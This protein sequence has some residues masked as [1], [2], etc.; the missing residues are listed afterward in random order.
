MFMQFLM[1]KLAFHVDWQLE[2]LG[3]IRCVDKIGSKVVVLSQTSSG[4][5]ILS[6]LNATS[7]RPLVRL[8]LAKRSLGFVLKGENII[9]DS[10]IVLDGS[11]GFEVGQ[12]TEQVECNKPDLYGIEIKKNTMY[13]RTSENGTSALVVELPVNLKAIEY[14]KTDDNETLEYIV[15]TEDNLYRYEKYENGDLISEWI[16]DES[17]SD[18][19]AYTIFDEE[20]HGL[21]VIKEE[22]FHEQ[23]LGLLEAYRYRINT[24]LQRMINVLIKNKFNIGRILASYFS[25]DDM[26]TMLKMDFQFGLAKQLVVAS[27]SGIVTS[28]DIRTGSKLWSINTGL[29]EIVSLQFIDES[30]LEIITPTVISIADLT[31]DPIQLSTKMKLPKNSHYKST[32][33]SSLVIFE[34][35]KGLHLASS[36]TVPH[37]DGHYVDYRSNGIKGYIIQGSML[38]PTWERK[39]KD[40]QYVASYASRPKEETANIG[41]ILGNRTVLY[42]YLNPNVG[43]YLVADKRNKTLLL[44][45]VDTITGESLY[46]AYHN[47]NVDLSLPINLL[48]GEHW[49]IYSYFSLDPIPEQKLVVV[50]LY[51]SLIPDNRI[52]IPGE[53]F[54]SLKSE[55]K[56]DAVAKS[57]LFPQVINS[58]AVSKTKYGITTKAILLQLDDGS[59]TYLPK[60]LISA[61]RKPESEMSQADKEEF[62]AAPYQ[63]TIPINDQFVVTHFRYLVPSKDAKLVSVSTNLE[64]TS[65]VCSI[66]HDIFCTR[67][68][69]SSQFDKLS[70][71]FEKGKLVATIAALLLA[72]Y[73]LR[74][75]VNQKKIKMKWLV[76]DIDITTL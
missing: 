25:E 33:D 32:I 44:D 15:S 55:F 37:I 59:I 26:S 61:R 73:I 70:A 76:K 42:K 47:E 4:D 27:K 40:D 36:D 39:L 5:S 62:M 14:L 31:S 6:W 18:I 13:Y 74:P 72:C 34:D 45:I 3:E 64:S 30:Q 68:S 17:C 41:V 75:M 71:S 51:E 35:K 48:F 60:Y 16:K 65:I 1:M 43:G 56:P 11:S 12:S 52:S 22:V 57:Y 8:P 69:P 24:N 9:L 7:G 28:L 53:S 38:Q 67:I 49:C 58:I 23:N 19:V 63:P 21:D 54:D 10:G 46:S 66:G 50:E 29:T 20:D 2:N